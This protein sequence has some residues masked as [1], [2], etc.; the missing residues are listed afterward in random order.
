MGGKHSAADQP[1]SLMVL[2]STANGLLESNATFANLGR[3]YGWKLTAG[4]DSKTT[5]IYADGAWWIL[6]DD[7]SKVEVREPR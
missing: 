2:C 4:Q 6:G 5:P 3:D 1:S 7:F